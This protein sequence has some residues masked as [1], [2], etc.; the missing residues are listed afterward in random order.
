M[1]NPPCVSTRDKRKTLFSALIMAV[2]DDVQN[3]SRFTRT[4]S[5]RK[6]GSCGMTFM[7]ERKC[8]LDI[9]DIEI[10][11]IFMSPNC[12]SSIRKRARRR[13]DFPLACVSKLKLT[14]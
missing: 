10:S 11:S 5:G 6:T 8:V 12:R 4:L 1:S 9:V 13:V 3:G 2:S 14:Q 7:R